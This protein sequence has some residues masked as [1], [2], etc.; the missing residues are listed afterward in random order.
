MSNDNQPASRKVAAL[1]VAAGRGVRSGLEV[2]KQYAA[3]GGKPVLR[4]AIEAMMAHHA[5]QHVLVVIGD[6]DEPRYQSATKGLP[7]LLPPVAGGASRQASVRNGLE[8]LVAH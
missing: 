4:R 3:I 2:P 1:I 8:A 7:N 5:V 6:G